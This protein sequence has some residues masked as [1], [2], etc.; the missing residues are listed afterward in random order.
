MIPRHCHTLAILATLAIGCAADTTGDDFLDCE[1][2]CDGAGALRVSSTWVP[3]DGFVRAVAG[4]GDIAVSP[5]TGV[6]LKGS[7]VRRIITFA[8]P[9]FYT[10]SS[11]PDQVRIRV[12]DDGPD[13]ELTSPAPGELVEHPPGQPITVT[14]RASDPLGQPLQLSIA[15]QRVE[16]AADGSFSARIPSRFGVNIVELAATD[17]AGNAFRAPRSFM[18]ATS[19]S[20]AAQNAV[21]SLDNTALAFLA[22]VI[23]PT[24]PEHVQVPAMDGP[25]GSDL[26]HDLFFDGATLPGQD[27][28]PGQMELHLRAVGDQLEV[29]YLVTGTAIAHGHIDGLL[30]S[31]ATVGIVDPQVTI[32]LEFEGGLAS[33]VTD[34]EVTDGG[35][36][37]NLTG[38]LGIVE[39]LFIARVRSEVELRLEKLAPT[40]VAAVLTGLDGELMV[41]TEAF[42]VDTPLTVRYRLAGLFVEGSQMNVNLAAKVS[43]SPLG[44]VA[45]PVR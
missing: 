39:D 27:G 16:V 24:L 15:D 17:A 20:G 37:L 18:A 34:I 23:T 45:A 36:E 19:Y 3:V 11:G 8:E 26:G 31:V 4:G 21:V 14:G 33:R 2:Q 38:I 42:N 43:G 35:V 13:I 44:D 10:L 12:S 25:I 7:P 9:G 30:E 6:E 29:K 28:N 22:S 41:D 40:L 1:G 5:E 32:M